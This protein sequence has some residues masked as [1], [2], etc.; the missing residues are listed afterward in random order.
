MA[1]KKK[2]SNYVTEKR[3]KAREDAIKAKKAYRTK[4]ITITTIAIVLAIACLVTGII[5]ISRACSYPKSILGNDNPKEEST[6]N[7]SFKATHH[8]AIEVEGYGTIHIELYGEEAPETVNNFVMLAEKGFYD[9]LTFHRIMDNFMIQGGD[10]KGNGTGGYEVDGKEQNIKGEFKENGVEN[11]IKHVRGTISMA[12][13]GAN[14]NSASSQFFIVH[15][16]SANNTASLDNKY[17]AFGMVTS[18]M[19][20]IDKIC[21]DVEEGSNGAVDKADQPV[22]KSISIHGHH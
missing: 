16:T 8:A 7:N 1:K 19:Q 13:E 11:D 17:A 4:K 14:M 20:I 5:L 12:R 18:G 15:Q 21:Y 6:V 22:I 2:N 3:T 9:G 10:P